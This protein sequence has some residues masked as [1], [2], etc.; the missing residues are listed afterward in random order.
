MRSANQA[1]PKSSPGYNPDVADAYPYDPEKAQGPPRP[2]RA[3][4]TASSFTMAIPGGNIANMERQGALIQDQ[5]KQGRDQGEDRA[6]PRHRHRHAVLHRRA[7]ATRSPR[8]TSRDKF[9]PGVYYDQWG[10]FQFVA[11]WNGAER[12]D[13]DNL[14][15]DAQSTTDP[16]ETGGA[17]EAGGQDRHRRGARGADRVHAPVHGVRQGPASAAPSAAQTDICDPP[18]L[19]AAPDEDEGLTRCRTRVPASRP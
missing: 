18:D 8:R 1:L 14:M 3:T 2:G 12:D 6:D 17:H 9:Y 16:A 19:H 7:R 5:L 15:L 13:I 10:K 4:R 11:I